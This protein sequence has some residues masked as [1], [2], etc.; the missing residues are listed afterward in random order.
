MIVRRLGPDDVVPTVAELD[1]IAT[2]M[3]GRNDGVRPVVRV[4]ERST[5][6]GSG[7]GAAGSVPR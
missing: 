6:P 3:T 5:I 1:A 7:L 4:L 2:S